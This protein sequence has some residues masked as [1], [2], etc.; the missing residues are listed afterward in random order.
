MISQIY[1]IY[2]AMSLQYIEKV[3]GGGNNTLINS[4]LYRFVGSDF[5]VVSKVGPSLPNR[6]A[7]INMS[8][9][10]YIKSHGCEKNSQP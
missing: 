4:V 3:V 9:F 7:C 8:I 1:A 2:G 5:V 10:M 6:V